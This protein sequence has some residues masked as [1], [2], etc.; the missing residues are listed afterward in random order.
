VTYKAKS[1]RPNMWAAQITNCATTECY[2]ILLLESSSLQYSLLLLT[3]SELTCGQTEFEVCI[4]SDYGSHTVSYPIVF[5]TL[6]CSLG[7]SSCL[8]QNISL[9]ESLTE[10]NKACKS[11]FYSSFYCFCLCL[12]LVSIVIMLVVTVWTTLIYTALLACQSFW[13]ILF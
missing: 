7:G 8:I 1:G 9:T 5:L 3:K 11:I 4:T 13:E 2:T 12:L 6:L 10:N